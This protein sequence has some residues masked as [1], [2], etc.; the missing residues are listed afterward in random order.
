MFF[1]SLRPTFLRINKTVLTV[2]SALTLLTVKR[3][4]FYWTR[5]LF[6]LNHIVKHVNSINNIFY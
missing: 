3:G 2:D 6:L 1:F 4:Q 5:M